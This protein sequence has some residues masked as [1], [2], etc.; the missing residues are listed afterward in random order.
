MTSQELRVASPN[1]EL[2]SAAIVREGGREGR[3]EGVGE[4]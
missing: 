3:R 1:M 2:T 4:E